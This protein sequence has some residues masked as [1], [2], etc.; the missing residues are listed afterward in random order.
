MNETNPC[1]TIL[2]AL[3]E[4]FLGDLAPRQRAALVRTARL[5][6][7]PAGRTLTSAAQGCEIGLVVDGLL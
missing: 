6:I 4:G 3:R 7:V 2:G 5:V 1:E